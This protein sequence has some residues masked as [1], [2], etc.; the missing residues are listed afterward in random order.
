MS[1][2]TDQQRR[3]ITYIER[4]EGEFSPTAAEIGMHMGPDVVKTRAAWG[5]YGSAI[6][7]PLVEAGFLSRHGRGYFTTERGRREAAL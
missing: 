6:A 2:L 7:N 4:V 3:C 5:K 1:S